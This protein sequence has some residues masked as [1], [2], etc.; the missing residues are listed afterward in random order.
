MSDEPARN[1]VV[2]TRSKVF[3]GWVVVA[4]CTLMIA[5][6]YGLMYSYSVFFKPLAD[7]FNWDRATVSLIYSASLIIR[8]VVAVGIGWLAD[9]YGSM[10]LMVFCGFMIGLGL[11]LSSQVHTLWQLFLAYAVV[12]AIGLSGTFG[13]GTAM[14]SRWFT[15][16]RGLALG[17]ASAGSGLGTLLIVPGTERLINAFGWSWAFF[18]CGTIAGVIMMASA[19]LL[20]PAPQSAML[21]AKKSVS[22]VE[23]DNNT[24]T[25]AQTGL[26][27][28]QAVRDPRMILLMAAFLLFFFSI[29]IIMVHLVNYATDMGVNPLV[30]ATFISLIGAVSIAGRLSTG[31]GADKIGIHNTLIMTRVFLVVSFICII[32]TKSLWAFY[33]FAVIFGLS[34]GGEIP[35]IPMFIGEYF[36]TKAMA[37]LVGLNAFVT[38]IG[39]AFGP[40]EA[41]KI[42]DTTRSYQGAFISG[43]L[44]GLLSLILVLILR[45]INRVVD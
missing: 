27:L 37:T 9:R 16:N 35:Q 19:L 10:K 25:T 38:S 17:I 24:T 23:T 20:R 21:G 5:I 3:Y 22:V 34:Y 29:Q 40:W 41:G 33:L 26:T 36:G 13:I 8:G 1:H 2:S 43:V 12:E 42:F 11:V 30:A 6:T 32:F 45:R 15:K 18:I 39:G 44:A 4:A 7:S 28:G 31:V 14:I